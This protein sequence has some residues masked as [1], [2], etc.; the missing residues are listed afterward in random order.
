[1]QSRISLEDIY[2]LVWTMNQTTMRNERKLEEISAQIQ[3]LQSTVNRIEHQLGLQPRAGDEDAIQMIMDAQRW[4]QDVQKQVSMDL[5]GF[6]AARSPVLAAGFG[7][8]SAEQQ[9]VVVI[10]DHEEK[11]E[12]TA[13]VYA[14]FHY[15][16]DFWLA[17]LMSNLRARSPRVS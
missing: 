10:D 9:E 14:L 11:A 8:S 3:D 7:V 5:V 6:G 1:M 13:E 17:K 2:G 16:P 4:I 12:S 15:L